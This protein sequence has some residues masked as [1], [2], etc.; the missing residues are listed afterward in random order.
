MTLCGGVAIMTSTSRLSAQAKGVCLGKRAQS[1]KFFYCRVMAVQNSLSKIVST[2]Y[3]AAIAFP[4]LQLRYRHS[5]E[6][7]PR[8]SDEPDIA[9]STF[10]IPLSKPQQRRR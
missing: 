7:T 3:I 4:I 8:E 10:V 9:P 1:N 2:F 6:V 5:R